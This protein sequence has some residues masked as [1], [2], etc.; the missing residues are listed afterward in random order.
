MRRQAPIPRSQS[1]A[2]SLGQ[3]PWAPNW[4]DPASIHGQC[5]RAHTHRQATGNGVARFSAAA[6]SF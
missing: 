1:M 4:Q 6:W 2:P 5:L 3:A